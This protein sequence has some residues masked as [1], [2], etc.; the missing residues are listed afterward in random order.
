MNG[1]WFCSQEEEEEEGLCLFVFCLFY[2]NYSQYIY[3]YISQLT[4]DRQ[5]YTH[6]TYI[7]D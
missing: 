4:D 3:I 7:M 6:N 1:D 2:L 5:A